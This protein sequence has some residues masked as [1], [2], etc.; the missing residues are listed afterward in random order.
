[1]DL[2]QRGPDFA[3]TAARAGVPP[4]PRLATPIALAAASLLLAEP[5]HAAMG[6]DLPDP[7]G[8]TL[9]ALGVAGLLIGRR[10]AGKNDD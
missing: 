2:Y 9:F 8:L 6:F 3:L 4:I 7:S 1:L 5:A 10:F